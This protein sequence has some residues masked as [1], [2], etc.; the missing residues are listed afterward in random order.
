MFIYF[1]SGVLEEGGAG[2]DAVYFG[3]CWIWI[4]R[5]GTARSEM[6]FADT[7]GTY[8]REFRPAFRCS[9]EPSR[10]AAG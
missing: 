7:V 9:D 8:V 6:R 2:Q 1:S 10:Q 4:S 5:S 3:T